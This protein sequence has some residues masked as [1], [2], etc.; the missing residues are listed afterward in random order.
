[1][2]RKY[3]GHKYLMSMMLKNNYA[4]LVKWNCDGDNVEDVVFKLAFRR[5]FSTTY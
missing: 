3:L 4:M 2:H 1:M 5:I